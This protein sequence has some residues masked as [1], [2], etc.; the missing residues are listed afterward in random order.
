MPLRLEDIYDASTDDEA[1]GCLALRLAE[2]IDARSGVLHWRSPGHA[3]EAEIS[4]SGY[5]SADHMAAYEELPWGTDLWAEAMNESSHRNR[6]WQMDSLISPTEYEESAIYNDWVKKIGD[7][8]FHCLGGAFENDSVVF[9]LGFHRG[10]TQRPF[11][12]EELT[13]MQ[14]LQ[15]PL[16]QMVKVR[17]RLLGDRQST[18]VMSSALDCLGTAVVKLNEQG[19]VIYR[20]EAAEVLFARGDGLAERNGQLVAAAAADQARLDE[21]IALASAAREP[22]AGA[23]PVRRSSGGVYACSLMPVFLDGH[24][25]TLM[26]VRDPA[27]QDGSLQYRLRTIYKL[28]DAEAAIALAIGQGATIDQIAGDRDTRIDTVRTQFKSL[29]AKMGCRRQ[30]DVAAIVCSMPLLNQPSGKANG[31]GGTLPGS[32]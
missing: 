2:E 29:A 20:N 11:S 25:T 17:Q 23:V 32:A 9:E 16:L 19:R 12:D 7:D 3:L 13:K 31:N 22:S 21:A 18:S 5:F 30:N 8:S 26:L 24:R 1:F 15:R 10:R 14:A 28:S 27:F 4:Y 6:L